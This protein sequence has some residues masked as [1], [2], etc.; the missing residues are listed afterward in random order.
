[1]DAYLCGDAPQGEPMVVRHHDERGLLLRLCERGHR[2][3]ALALQCL[4]RHGGAG[5]LAPLD[6]DTGGDL[7]PLG[8]RGG[9]PDGNRD[10][11]VPL[12]RAPERLRGLAT[13]TVLA[14][15]AIILFRSL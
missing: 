7:G 12:G 13:A 6:D 1:M 5:L 10:R 14:V 8:C 4:L 2:E 11:L 15:A 9:D 3:R